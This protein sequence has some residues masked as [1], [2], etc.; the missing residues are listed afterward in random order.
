MSDFVFLS[1]QGERERQEDF[2]ANF[3]DEIFVICDGLS[4]YP[5]GD[6]AA[7][8]ATLAAVAFYKNKEAKYTLENIFAMVN[9]AV[10]NLLQTL[11]LYSPI[12]TTM[13]VVQLKS[14]KASFGNAGDSRGY[15][16]SKDNLRQV[17]EDH[18]LGRHLTRALGMDE[19]IEPDFYK[20]EVA[21]GDVILLCTDGLT[22]FVSDSVI[23]QILGSDKGLK[24]Q[25]EG[26]VETALQFGST[27]NVTVGLI[28]T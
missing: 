11:G 21:K 14:N 7:K 18:R 20:E 12:G 25:A 3:E 15:I 13:V 2:Y 27:D 22:D 23:E 10:Y 26:L 16:F 6:Q 17:T 24:A 9:G 19:K 1:E 5:H 4:G 28:K 8:A